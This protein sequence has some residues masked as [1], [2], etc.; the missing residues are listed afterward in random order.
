[1]KQFF[2]FLLTLPCILG[3]ANNVQISNIQL[4]NQ[5]V[6]LNTYQ[7][8]F[9]ISWDN[10]WRT[11]TLESNWDA[12]WIFLKYKTIDNP[13]WNHGNLRTTGFVEPTGGTISVPTETGVIG[14]G[15]FLYRSA[16][17]IGDVNYSN[18]ELKWDY[19]GFI[20]DDAIVEVCVFA[21][22]MVYIPG[23]PFEVGD[24]GTTIDGNFEAGT[25]T[26]PFTINNENAL[27]LGGG[28]NANL[29]NNNA[30]GMLT[31]DD[32]NDATNQT[33]PLNYPK[34]TNPF[35]IM[36]YEM[37][38]GQWAAFLNKLNATASAVR[39]SD[40]DGQNN[41]TISNTGVPPEIYVASAPDRA[42]NFISWQDLA[43]Y[44]DWSALRPMSEL[45]YEKACRGSLPA[46]PDECAWGN[47]YAYNQTY[48]I[49]NN[50][51]PNEV[52]T[53]AAA[54]TGNAIYVLTRPLNSTFSWRCGIFAASA[55]TA[56]RQ[57]T[58][59]T[60]Y[61]VMEMSGNLWEM[62]V[63]VGA[64]D[65]R[66]F[67]GNIHGNGIIGTN[68]GNSTVGSSWPDIAGVNEGV[69]IGVRGGGSSNPIGDMHVSTR[70]LATLTIASRFSDVS[71][72]LGRSKL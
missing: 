34:G 12:V 60:Y 21:I 11:S 6:V 32:F 27:T 50:G 67:N 44:A 31:P 68:T 56:S 18:V 40:M 41:H 66:S 24:D 19:N 51:A 37:S 43:A 4:T 22:E 29:N 8:R 33:L 20:N 63:S 36:K 48:I 70:R 47:P 55:P 35:Y 39:F 9:D 45:E 58:G 57:E 7:V 59:A 61:G 10:S 52:I 17:G 62:C 23:G 25:S 72:R 14:Y 1:M 16:N 15:A 53:N 38:Q 71:G 28:S 42:C 54:G 65:G 2:L 69:G 46:V 13:N 49:A 26:N 64:P 3:I 5:D 30:I